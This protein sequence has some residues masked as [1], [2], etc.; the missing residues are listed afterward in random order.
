MS[1]K[2]IYIFGL[3]KHVRNK[4]IP[5]I[6]NLEINIKGIISHNNNHNYPKI[7]LDNLIEYSN[8]NIN[9]IISGV[10]IEHI[11]L[12]KRVCGIK[13]ANILVEKPIFVDLDKFYE[14]KTLIVEKK[15][16]E[17]MMYK[18]NL[19]FRYSKFIYKLR[20]YEINCINIKFILPMKL[21]DLK[22][23]FRYTDSIKNSIIYDI[24]YYIFDLLWS[25]NTKI[26]KIIV[27]S[28]NW[29]PNRI[30]KNISVKLECNNDLK[31]Y[32]IN[33]D[34][35][36]GTKYFNEIDMRFMNNNIKIAPFFSGR[37]GDVNFFKTDYKK[38]YTKVKRNKNS[39]EKMIKYWY[40]KNS[41]R[42]SLGLGSN[43]RFES[44]L[45]NLKK[46][47]EQV[48]KYDL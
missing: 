29:Y 16:Q 38:S 24:G 28:I 11:N 4:L 17:G 36:Y 1:D 18:F 8:A 35:G 45:L 40:A 26:N 42:N 32:I 7:S 22:Q 30:L 27:D 10:P 14:N 41:F 15:I 23:S 5:A 48:E 31:K 43:N 9:I 21:S 33:F 3:G 2:G 20:R 13:R 39:Y 37:D 19:A 25:Y 34:I 6:K 46:I 44:I 12:I 47:E